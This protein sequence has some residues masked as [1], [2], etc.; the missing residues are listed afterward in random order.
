M[1]LEDCQGFDHLIHHWKRKDSDWESLGHH[2]FL[3]LVEGETHFGIYRPQ[4]LSQLQV[5]SLMFLVTQRGCQ[6]SGG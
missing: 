4:N 3:Q 6:S 1:V 5:I 2:G